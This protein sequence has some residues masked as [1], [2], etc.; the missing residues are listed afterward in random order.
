[1][2]IERKKSFQIL[3]ERKKITVEM[4]QSRLLLS[5]VLLGKG[6]I[7]LSPLLEKC[8]IKETIEVTPKGNNI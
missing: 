4:Y 2:T 3:C 8:E 5:S 1:M 6:E 7:K